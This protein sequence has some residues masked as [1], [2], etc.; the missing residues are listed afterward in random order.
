MFQAMY[1]LSVPSIRTA[2]AAQFTDC[3]AVWG[4]DGIVLL[5][6][7]RMRLCMEKNVGV[8]YTEIQFCQCKQS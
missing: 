3:K 2:D 5:S 1:N 6:P 8:L 7:N 4:F